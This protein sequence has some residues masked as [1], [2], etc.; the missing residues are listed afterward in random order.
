MMIGVLRGSWRLALSI[1]SIGEAIV[2]AY[3]LA[4]RI[5][6]WYGNRA[7]LTTIHQNRGRAYAFGCSR[8][9]S[10]RQILGET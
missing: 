7:N 5:I 8:A 6:S 3:D 4:V 10:T 9:G 2:V 1:A